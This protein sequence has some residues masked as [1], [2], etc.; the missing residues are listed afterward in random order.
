MQVVKVRVAASC[1]SQTSCKL[2]NQLASTLWITSHKM[3]DITTCGKSVERINVDASCKT[4]DFS[5]CQISDLISTISDL[6][7]KLLVPLLTALKQTD[8]NRR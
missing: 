4:S 8:Q 2:L 5:D 1:H 6:T 7:Y 3:S